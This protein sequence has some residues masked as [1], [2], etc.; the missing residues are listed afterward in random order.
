MQ[1]AGSGQVSTANSVVGAHQRGSDNINSA[2]TLSLLSARK[3]G[4]LLLGA[5]MALAII[6]STQEPSAGLKQADADYRAGVAALSRNDLKAALADFESVVRL[7]P[8]AE[9]GHSALGAVLV[10]LGRMNDG[11][12]ELEKALAMKPGDSSAQLNLALAYQQSGQAAK[13]LPLFTRL[14]SAARGEKHPLAL[15]ILVPYAHAL[16]AANQFQAAT[17]KMKEAV[18]RD[19]RNAE[20]QD[21]L[22]SLY[23]QHQDWPNAEQA[24]SAALA[25]KP[26][27]AMAHLHLGLTRKAKQQPGALDELAK[28][29]QLAP[30]NAVI[31]LQFGQE[32][33]N[34][35]QDEQAVPVLE[36]AVG[37]DPKSTAAAYQLGLVLQ[38]VNRLEEA[39]VLLQRAASAE[40]KNGEVLINL[41]MALTQTQKAKDAVPILQRAVALE[42]ENPTAHQDLAAAYIQLNQ[43]E[44]AV[45]QLRMALKL[46]PDAPQL[47]YNLGLAFKM[48]DDAVDAIPELEIAEKLDASAPEPPYILGVLY[49]QVGRYAD[50]ARELSASLKLRP[51]NGDAWA[52][53]GSVYNKLD[54]LPDA[55]SA[56]REAIRQL[57]RQADPHLTLAAVLIKQNQPAEATEER[58]KAADLMRANMNRQRAEV[59]TNAANSQM[60]SGNLEQAISQFREALSYDQDYGEAHAGLANALERQGKTAEAAGERQKAAE[61]QT[62]PE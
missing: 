56:L 48:Q 10:R 35:G 23:A 28:A 5:W 58:R 6:G 11:I 25:S 52:T 36:H 2:M 21:E 57:P 16:A 18:A 62:I 14:E 15:S 55:V 54:Q 13:A 61:K 37:I 27:F 3:S 22:G 20:L 1:N 24:F 51:E 47:H 50:A 29:Y 12:R 43:T 59:A 39:I 53:L 17:T 60:K 34:A 44:D 30:D 4:S 45:N 31:A 49:M 42:P 32:L 38:R 8:S 7:A 26:D 46:S 40:P 19:P 33:A 9:Q 41:G